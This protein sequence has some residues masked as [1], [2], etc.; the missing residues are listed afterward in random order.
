MPKA[1][2]IIWNVLTTIVV[3]VV[4][5]GA[6]FLMGSRL[7]G[8]RVFTVLTGSMTPTYDPGD[9]IYVKSVPVE[10]IKVGDPLTFILNENL[11]IATHRVVDIDT[12]HQ[13]FYTKGDANSTVDDPVHFKNVIGVPQFRIRWLGWVSNFIQR[14]PGMYIT[15]VAIA[16]LLILAL[17]P[18][19]KAKKCPADEPSEQTAEVSE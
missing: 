8:Y 13:R 10:E 19:R 14:P 18:E 3:V 6:V 2:K 4:V 16:V 15:I 7:L 12:E 11:D 1:L 17:L 9:L 5:L